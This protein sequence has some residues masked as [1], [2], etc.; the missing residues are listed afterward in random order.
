MPSG[1]NLDALK[2]VAPVEAGHFVAGNELSQLGIHYYGR[3]GGLVYLDALNDGADDYTDCDAVTSKL[4]EAMRRPP[5]PSPADLKSFAAYR[6]WRMRTGGIALPEAKLRAEFAENP[7][8]SVGNRS[9]PAFVPQ[10]ILAGDH[11]H[12]YSQIRVPILVF[13]GYPGPPQDQIRE[14]HRTDLE[15]RIN[16][17]AVYG[18][19]VGMTKN[20][21]KRIHC[22]AGGARV[23]ALWGAAHLVFCRTRP[24]CCEKCPPFWRVSANLSRSGIQ[25]NV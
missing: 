22:A 19:Q 4:P 14:N 18:T 3:I 25:L 16:M 12:D 5:S 20:R 1:A 6:G 8:G 10:A 2:L 7:D 23:V 15:E 13:V 9:T 21:I 11:K 17:E 24:M